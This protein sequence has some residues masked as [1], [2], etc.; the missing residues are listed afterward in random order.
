MSMYT[1]SEATQVRA[2]AKE[3]VQRLQDEPAYR[4]QVKDNP[5]E[6]L[7]SSGM[8]KEA[9]PLFLQDIGADSE[10]AGYKLELHN[11]FDDVGSC[12]VVGG[13]TSVWSD[14]IPDPWDDGFWKI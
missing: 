7:T 13:G 12:N 11:P 9:V 2:T 1:P 10:V 3:I 4:Q 14:C 6:T 5:V 8:P